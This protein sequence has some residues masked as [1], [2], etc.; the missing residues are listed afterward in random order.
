M[1]KIFV[2]LTIITVLSLFIFEQENGVGISSGFSTL[3]YRLVNIAAIALVYVSM[4]PIIRSSL[5][6]MPGVTM[7]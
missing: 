3:A 6:D 5:P 1:I 7:L 4:I 2:P